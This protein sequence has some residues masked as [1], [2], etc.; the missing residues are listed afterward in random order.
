[1]TIETILQAVASA[2]HKDAAELTAQ[3]KEGEDWKSEDDISSI[4]SDTISNDFKAG[5]E[6][7]AAEVSKTGTN[8]FLKFAKEHGWIPPEGAKYPQMLGQFSDW[9]KEQKPEP[10]EPGKKPEEMTEAELAKLPIVKRLIDAR[11]QAV[12]SEKETLQ[13]EFEG[14]KKQ[15][16][17]KSVEETAKA[18]A[19]RI[20]REK[21][22]ILETDGIPEEKRIAAFHRLIDWSKVGLDA[23]GKP[24]PVNED[25]EQLTDPNTGRPITFESMVVAENPYGFHTVDPKKGGA[26]PQPGSNAPAGNG[27]ISFASMDDYNRFIKTATDPKQIELAT[28][29]RIEQP[30]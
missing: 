19:V 1:M 13:S 27:K 14:Y 25:G 30:E 18:E 11:L 2:L 12:T 22:A 17:R 21:K 20:L 16:T 5:R 9:L 26:Q 4:L 3:L 8:A 7:K 15:Q 28:Q 6:S 29:W 24:I 10:T 23:N